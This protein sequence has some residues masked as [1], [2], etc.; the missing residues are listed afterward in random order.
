MNRRH[1][2]VE[3]D[4]RMIALNRR[5]RRMWRVASLAAAGA[6]LVGAAGCG[7]DDDVAAA[8]GGTEGGSRIGYITATG[9]SYYTCVAKGLR[10]QVEGAGN[11]YLE[12]V[13]EGTPESEL[14]AAEDLLA[15]DADVV[16]L[17]SVAPR[18]G[19]QVVN[20][21]AESGK[22]V[23]VI[24]NDAFLTEETRPKVAATYA[25][26]YR[27]LGASAG[28]VAVDSFPAGTK[29]AAVE[30]TPGGVH[31]MY[32]GFKD[33]VTAAGFEWRGFFPAKTYSPADVQSATEDLLTSQ[34]D[35][36]VIYTDDTEPT[37]AIRAAIAAADSDAVIVPTG[38]RD[39]DKDLVRDGS[40]LG[41]SAVSAYPL[42][43]GAGR[44]VNALAAGDAVPAIP[45]PRPI[46]ASEANL[47]EVPNYC[48]P[49]A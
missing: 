19:N 38:G 35:V 31:E 24:N 18:G 49:T 37:P 11:T 1:T 20:V 17:L 44:I 41:Y 3:G 47:D 23:V 48:S 28:E 29:A 2:E 12:A 42:G 26:D 5:N 27:E 45:K 13:T 39:E 33:T 22:K 7:D 15:Q 25:W 36:E 8:E 46:A 32:E 43:E 6:L 21:A 30:P 9:V 4:G 34:P 14:S 16:V 10:D 40:L